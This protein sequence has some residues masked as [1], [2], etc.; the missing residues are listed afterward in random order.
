MVVVENDGNGIR[1][2]QPAFDRRGIHDDDS[3]EIRRKP[4]S[5]RGVFDGVV[6][7]PIRERERAMTLKARDYKDPQCVIYD[8]ESLG[9]S[10][11]T[12]THD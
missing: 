8:S 7:L 10:K 4:R 9:C 6:S 2:V 11:Q 5:M 3:E 1:C 12:Y